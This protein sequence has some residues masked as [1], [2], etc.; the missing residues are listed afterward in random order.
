MF[1]PGSTA[2]PHVEAGKLKGL[3]VTSRRRTA[4]APSIPTMAEAGL[5]E[6]EVAMWNGLSA[7]AGT[8]RD[9]V[10][11]LAAAATKA[12][13]SDELRSKI[14]ANGGDPIVMGPKEFSDYIREDIRRWSDVI[15]EAGIKPQ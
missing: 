4:L 3:A 1:A 12:L 5:P 15:R 9:V 14:K 7:P 11:R 10:D 13:A 2:L 8:P 6:Y